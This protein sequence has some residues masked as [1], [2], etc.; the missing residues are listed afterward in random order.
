MAIIRWRPMFDT[1]DVDKFFEDMPMM[2]GNMQAFTPA[3]DVYHDKDNVIAETPLAGVDPDKVTVSIENDVLKIEGKVEHKSEV[4]DKNYYR[5]EV[6]MGSFYRAVAL[7]THVKGDQA[8]AEF[9]NGMLKI[10]IPKAE[11]VKPKTIK[12]A[13]KKNK[14]K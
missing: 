2:P 1:A 8:K 3:V 4:D 11:E 7:P 9:E 12:I 14:T 10:T 13:V 5:K 6:R